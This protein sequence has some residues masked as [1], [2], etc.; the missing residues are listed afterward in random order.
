MKTELSELPEQSKRN[1]TKEPN[2][3]YS[4]WHLLIIGKDNTTIKQ[5]KTNKF[6]K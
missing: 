6:K 3:Y 1:K 2:I 5:I 4:F